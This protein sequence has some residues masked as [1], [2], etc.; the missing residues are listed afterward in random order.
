MVQA[1]MDSRLKTLFLLVSLTMLLFCLM[2]FMSAYEYVMNSGVFGTPSTNLFN[3]GPIGYGLLTSIF[4]CAYF[5]IKQWFTFQNQVQF[6][7]FL[8]IKCVEGVK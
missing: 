5:W 6:N 8:P 4:V 7:R 1:T 3:E 2:W